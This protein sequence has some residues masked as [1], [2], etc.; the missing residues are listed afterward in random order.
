[1][2]QTIVSYSLPAIPIVILIL[3][4]RKP[5]SRT[6]TTVIVL[7]ILVS[8]LGFLDIWFDSPFRGDI[9]KG[10]ANI[11]VI[12]DSYATLDRTSILNDQG[13]G[14]VL[15]N[16]T[17]DVLLLLDTV[18]S[19]IRPLKDGK[20]MFRAVADL[21]SFNPGFGMPVSNL[22]QAAVGLVLF[23]A[24]PASSSVIS[25]RVV[26]GVNEHLLKTFNIDPQTSYE[27]TDQPYQLVGLTT[28]NLEPLFESR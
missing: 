16:N 26:L 18:S 22:K 4:A 24:M 25:G 1:M 8:A 15:K 28:K 21:D 7:S 3:E 11:E 13:A 17:G 10:T 19:E 6:R 12:V 27:A 9:E 5:S 23:V 20:V 14:F 2:I